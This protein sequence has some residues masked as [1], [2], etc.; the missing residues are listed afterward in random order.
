MVLEAKREGYRSGLYTILAVMDAERDLYRAR[1]DYAVARY[2]YIMN[3]L[4]LKKA[5]GTLSDGDIASINDWFEK[6]P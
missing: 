5:V 4:R 2:D 3:S 1:R 6:E